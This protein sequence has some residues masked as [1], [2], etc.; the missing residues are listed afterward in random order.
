[1]APIRLL[2]LK[3]FIFRSPLWLMITRPQSIGWNN[4]QRKEWGQMP[5]PP[6]ESEESGQ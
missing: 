1:L 3:D 2:D 6:Q 5:K 4:P